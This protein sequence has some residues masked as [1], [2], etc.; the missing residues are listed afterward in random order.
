MPSIPHGGVLINRT[1]P[2]EVADEERRRAKGLPSLP[3]DRDTLWD[4]EKIAIGAF[5]PLTGFMTLEQVKSVVD[6]F[7]LP[8]GE[9]WSMPILCPVPDEFVDK[10]KSAKEVA[11]TDQ[12]GQPIATVQVRDVFRPDKRW[13]VKGVFGTDDEKHPGV[14]KVLGEPDWYLG[15]EVTLLQP[16]ENPYRQ[17]ERTPSQTRAYFERMGWQTV[18]G[19]Q[20]RNA[21]HRAHEYLQR[22]ALEFC[23][24]LLIQPIMGTKKGDD[25][26]TEAIM[27]AYEVLVRQFYPADRVLLSGITTWMR[28]GGPRE[29]VFHALFRKNYGC[30]HFIVGRDH[31]GVGNFYDPYAA[32]RIFDELPDLGITILKVTAAFYCERCGC[33]A[34]EKTCGHPEARRNISMTAL[35]TMLRN[36]EMPPS[37]L[38]RPEIAETLR[39][40]VAN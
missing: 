2:D 33:L 32:H 23:D 4:A 22:C 5:S 31:A 11:L 1:L 19:F 6:E 36:G 39:Q 20:T 12:H 10:V 37:E 28:Y 21:P 9:V 26:P 40:F 3:A 18:V 29:A 34:T 30:T 16:P 15:G 27:T 25:F 14:A 7:R 8:S 38:I 35:R 13:L 17:W 24:G